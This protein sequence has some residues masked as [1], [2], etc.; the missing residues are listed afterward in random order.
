MLCAPIHKLWHLLVSEIKGITWYCLTVRRLSS[1][2]LSMYLSGKIQNTERKR[3][4]QYMWSG[5]DEVPDDTICVVV[6]VLCCAVND[7]AIVFSNYHMDCIPVINKLTWWIGKMSR[8][9][10]KLSMRD[11]SKERHTNKVVY[12]DGCDCHDFDEI[13]MYGAV[14]LTQSMLFWRCVVVWCFMGYHTGMCVLNTTKLVKPFYS[15]LF[16]WY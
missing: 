9:E 4:F 2:D 14:R 3:E 5:M 13:S 6:P 15:S 16:T 10:L 12:A 11:K 8:R 1:P 7:E